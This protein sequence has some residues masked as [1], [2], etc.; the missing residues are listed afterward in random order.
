[1]NMTPFNK[2]NILAAIIAMA[3]LNACQT[4][5][6]KPE[7]NQQAVALA[8]ATPGGTTL[9]R[10]EFP[11]GELTRLCKEAMQKAES[12]VND[13]IGIPDAQRNFTNTVE[14]LDQLG[15]DFSDKTNPLIFMGYVS[16]NKEI[17][18]EASACESEVGQFSVSLFT[19]RELYDAWKKG[20]AAAKTEKLS[21]PAKRLVEQ[22]RRQFIK[23]G[24]ELDD[25]K[26][27]E[28]R[29]LKKTLAMTE[30]EFSKN[31]NEATDFAAFTTKEL[32]GVP[33]SILGRLEK[34]PDGR[35]KVTTKTPDYV[36]VMENASNPLT[37]QTLQ[38]VYEN[39]ARDKNIALLDQA[40]LLLT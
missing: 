13:L 21:A 12:E 24:L 40:I 8:A 31:L 30:A 29:G 22:T 34:Q 17:R 18:D 28:V 16:T 6:P 7:I 37:R 3:L 11:V 25:A 32:I 20:M 23:N 35:I 39:R 1:M 14:G 19:R 33:E 2:F 4:T 15:A 10:F 38:T 9:I 36:P 26:L 5:A 27:A